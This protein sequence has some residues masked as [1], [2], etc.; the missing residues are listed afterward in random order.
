MKQ[1][2]LEIVT[3]GRGTV[4]I[5]R[6][7]GGVVGESGVRTGVAQV[8]IHHTSASLIISE[9][10]DPAVHRDLERVLARL[11]PDGDPEFEHDAEGPDDMPA[12]V[13]AMLTAVAISIPVSDGR[14]ALGTWQGIYVYEHRTAPHRRRVTVTVLGE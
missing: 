13:R 9:N 12:H 3:R 7:V 8:F 1:G 2:K 14:L 6:E 11:A 5:T 10:A 4:D